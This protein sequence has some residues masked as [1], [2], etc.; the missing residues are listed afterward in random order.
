MAVSDVSAWVIPTTVFAAALQGDRE[1]CQAVLRGLVGRER[2][3]VG[4]V[5]AR[6]E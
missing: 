6:D 1:L 4:Q 5:T 3:L 2:H